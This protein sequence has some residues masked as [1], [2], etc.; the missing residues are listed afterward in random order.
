MDSAQSFSPLTR[1]LFPDSDDLELRSRLAN[2]PG[3]LDSM[4]AGRL[5][6][7]SGW[8]ALRSFLLECAEQR[9]P[10][11]VYG[12]YDVDGSVSSTLMFRWLRAHG[13]PANIFLPSRFH[14]GYGLDKGIIEK[15]AG[16]GYK[17][18]LA[19]DCGTANIEEIATACEQ[20]LEVAVVDH[21]TCKDELPEACLLNP[22]IDRGLPALCTAGLAYTI[23]AALRLEGVGEAIIPPGE[24]PINAAQDG[25]INGSP[26]GFFGDELELAGIAT[27]ADVVPLEPLNWALGHHAL[28]RLPATQN[29]GLQ[30][31]LKVSRLNGLSRITGR[32]AGFDIIP[33]LNAAGRMAQARII[34]ELF[35]ADQQKAREI[36][37]QIEQ[38]NIDRKETTRRITEQA[39][40]QA[41]QYVEHS[42]LLLHDSAWHPG[43]LGIVAARVAEQ[44][45][46]PAIVL[47]DAPGKPEL[48]AGSVRSSGGIDVIAALA[49]CERH[50]TS[51]GGHAAAA[52]VKLNRDSLDSLREAWHEAVGC[53]AQQI[54][55]AI[56]AGEGSLT[57]LL[58]ITLGEL[59]GQF[60]ADIWQL[61]P[62]DRQLHP[63]PRF[64]LGGTRISRADYMG[65]DRTHIALLVTDNVRQC[66]VVG[67]NMS[68]L[69]NRLKVGDAAALIVECEPDNWNNKN[70]M[71]LRLVEVAG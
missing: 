27:I 40:A 70:G 31:L 4:L 38:L 16:Q 67:F 43:V 41:L 2:D 1:R 24:G 61:Q 20:G 29:H 36:A 58:T 48:W 8:P 51:F 34:P 3:L 69:L 21:H 26:R 37:R 10:T 56:A 46:K 15:M 11:L 42:A 14:H 22:H 32:Q 23:L 13:V 57:D 35:M 19:L 55:A 7:A 71:V 28:K 63:M 17:R 60:E 44:H 62:F 50:L 53:I 39:H 45:G 68:H 59:S 33:R 6:K 30:E 54:E 47:A 25:A 52:G 18:L 65:S 5:Q 12:D 64:I 66:R 9:I 49:E